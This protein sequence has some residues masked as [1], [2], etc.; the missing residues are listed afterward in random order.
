[1]ARARHN[2]PRVH[3]Q[4]AGETEWRCNTGDAVIV[5]GPGPQPFGSLKCRAVIFAVGP[6]YTSTSH[7]IRDM[8]SLLDDAY[9]EAMR[10]AEKGTF[11]T[12]AFPLI[13]TGI[14]R[15][16]RPLK[17]VLE[18]AVKAVAESSY[19]GLERV[20]LVAYRPDEQDT[21]VE[22]AQEYFE[23]LRAG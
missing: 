20:H 13:S 6:N 3:H 14:F 8:D 19:P 23:R 4:P 18:I 10:L 22:A 2:L 12:V 7:Q 9:V 17:T 11:K 21:L 5:T 1:M 16:M 15:G